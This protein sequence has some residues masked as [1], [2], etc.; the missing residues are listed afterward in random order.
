MTIPLRRP[1]WGALSSCAAL[2][3]CLSV[4]AWDAAA[5]ESRPI[6]RAVRCEQ[7]PKIDGRLDDEV[8]QTSG[9]IE[10][11]Q[12]KLP[13]AYGE[14]SSQTQIRI[15]YDSKFLY[16]GVRALDAEADKIIARKMVRDGNMSGDDRI[17]I[18]LDT[19]S[20]LRN[21]YHFEVNPLGNKRDGL[22]ENGVITYEWDGIWYADARIDERGYVLEIAIPFQTLSIASD[23]TSWGLQVVRYTKRNGEE[24]RWASPTPEIQA[25][26]MKGNGR[27]EGLVGIEQGI[28]LDVVPKLAIR[29][30]DDGSTGES[31]TDVDPGLDLFYRITPSLTGALT[32]NTD[33]GEAE[34]DTR[35]INLTRFSLFFPEKR[36]FFLQDE[37]I[38]DFGG[39]QRNPLPFFSRRIGLSDQGE[40]IPILV[41]GK[42]TGRVGPLNVGLLDVVTDEYT[43]LPDPEEPADPAEKIGIKN[44]AVARLSL[45]LLEES[46]A[47]VIFTSGDPNS[48]DDNFLFGADVNYRNSQFLS[49]G[50]T[51]VARG[52][53]QNSWTSGVQSEQL[54]WGSR[55]TYPN[56]RVNWYLIAEEVQANFRPALG[57]TSRRGIRNYYAGYRFRQRPRRWLRTIDHRL[58]GSLVTHTSGRFESARITVEALTIENAAGD[59]LSLDY[60]RVVEDLVDPFVIRPGVTIPMGRYS[61]NRY[62]VDVSSSNGRALSAGM[63]ISWGGFFD[64]H[65][66]DL[67]PSISWRPS[68]YLVL[69]LAYTH[70]DIPLPGGKVV[71]DLASLKADIQFNPKVS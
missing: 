18:S 44:L 22:I 1:E 52:W 36:Q 35:Q 50:R 47:G 11:L 16:I 42:V 70:N 56:D 17:T 55:L 67:E 45:N 60:A 15:L 66:V 27:L 64:G 7:A 8:W 21:G 53:I 63:R 46:T 2:A 51:L 3:C 20:D 23:R 58:T 31:N 71:V 29:Y 25:F 33:F 61:W 14:A 49:S 24:D 12:Q 13:V 40:E 69:S 65:R 54:A 41:G 34:V 30:L 43:R 48:S 9:V 38:F 37:G 39:L 6:V 4:L 10:G 62:T 19:F 28:G 26:N 59:R 32:V 57:F 68:R 5:E